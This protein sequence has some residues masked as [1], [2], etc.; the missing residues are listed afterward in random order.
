MLIIKIKHIK[1]LCLKYECHSHRIVQNIKISVLNKSLISPSLK[2]F[3][4]LIISLFCVLMALRNSL[5]MSN[6]L[7]KQ[8]FVIK[9][10]EKI[11]AEYIQFN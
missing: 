1:Y 6:F 9:I 2:R 3:F 8:L 7:N 5:D 11:F 4:M 10:N